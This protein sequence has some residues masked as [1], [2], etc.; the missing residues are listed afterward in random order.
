MH[1]P[2]HTHTQ[3]HNSILTVLQAVM[4]NFYYYDLCSTHILA[5]ICD[6]VVTLTNNSKHICVAIVTN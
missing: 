2:A 6:V 4:M 5:K 3:T 1:A